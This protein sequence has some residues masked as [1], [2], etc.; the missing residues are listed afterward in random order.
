MIIFLVH[1]LRT[2]QH[3]FFV[4]KIIFIILGYFAVLLGIIGI[5]LPL[6]PTTVF[7]LIGS[8]FFMKGSP[9]LNE[10]LLN[11]K[12]LGSYIKNYKEKK[13]MP[14]RA[15]VTTIIFLWCSICFTAFFFISN[16]LIQIL[17]FAIAICVTIYL[18]R[19]KTIKIPA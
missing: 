2:R 3:V 15:K 1:I 10:K 18:T 8:Y 6:L 12:Y 17:L 16:T 9:R 4:K 13:G 5:F 19:L 14:L 11:S 7:L